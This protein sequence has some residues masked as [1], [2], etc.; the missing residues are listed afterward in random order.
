VIRN[1]EYPIASAYDTSIFTGDLVT[2]VAGGTIEQAAA[3]SRL[4]GVFMGVQYVDTNTG[5]QVYSKYWPANKAASS[6]KALVIDDPDVVFI[7]Q[8]D[9]TPTDPDDRGLVYEITVGTGSTVHGTSAME[10]ATA[11]GGTSAQQMRALGPVDEP[12][13]DPDA[14]NADWYVQINEHEFRQTAGV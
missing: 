11:G 7:M 9:G 10:L 6:V 3:A 13:N 14:A 12:G 4:L 1:R 8:H 5:E 2:L